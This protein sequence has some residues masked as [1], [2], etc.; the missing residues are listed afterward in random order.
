MHGKLNKNFWFCA[1][2][3][4][5][6]IYVYLE[7]ATLELQVVR[8]AKQHKHFIKV[9]HGHLGICFLAKHCE[10]QL[11]NAVFQKARGQQDAS[12]F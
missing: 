11:R 12:L 1:L 5:A 2:Q 10:A 8:Q 4:K 3:Q 9:K 7:T 6:Q